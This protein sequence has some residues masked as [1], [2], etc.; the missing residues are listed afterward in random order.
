MRE[1]SGWNVLG[2]GGG[3]AAGIRDIGEDADDLCRVAGRLGGGDERRHVGTAPRDQDG[4]ALL[5]LVQG[6][7]GHSASLPSKVTG[8]APASVMRPMMAGFLPCSRS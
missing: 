3:E 4:D 2:G 8:S 7:D 6:P 5:A 1:S